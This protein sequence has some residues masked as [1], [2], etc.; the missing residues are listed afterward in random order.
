MQ[1]SL[2]RFPG[3]VRRPVRYY[4]K[5]ECLSTAN[6]GGFF[7]LNFVYTVIRIKDSVASGQGIVVIGQGSGAS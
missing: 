4:H 2:Q 6:I 1:A 5:I 7:I 3:L